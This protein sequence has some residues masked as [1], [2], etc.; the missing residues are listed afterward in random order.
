M[1]HDLSSPYPYSEPPFE[2]GRLAVP[3]APSWAEFLSASAS[4]KMESDFAL[5]TLSDHEQRE[6][7][8]A[9]RVIQTAF[10]KYKVRRLGG[11]RERIAQSW[12]R[13]TVDS[14]DF[15]REDSHPKWPW[16]EGQG[17]SGKLEGQITCLLGGPSGAETSCFPRRAGG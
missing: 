6:L 16:A 2:R 14:Q 5:L 1:P 9:A 12:S 10:R 13:E 4:G 7:Y 17:T 3:P 11:L 8:E 15:G